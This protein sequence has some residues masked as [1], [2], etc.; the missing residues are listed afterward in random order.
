MKKTGI[1]KIVLLNLSL[2]FVFMACGPVTEQEETTDVIVYGGTSGAVTAAIQAKKMG[3]SVIMISPDKHLGGLT[4]GGLGWTDT[5][6]KEVIGG[7]SREFYQ[8]VYE[9]YTEDGAWKWEAQSDF[10]NKGQGTPA[11]DGE[12][13]TMWI[14]EPHVAEEVYDE[15]IE[16]LGI[17]V[18]RDEWLDRESG[19][20]VENGK[21]TAI[22]TLSGKEFKGKMFVD[23]TYEGDLMAAAGVSYHVGREGTS[24]YGEDWNGVQTGVFH[25]KHHFK[26]VDQPI[27][28]YIIPGDPSSGLLPKISGEDPGVKGEGDNKVQAYCFRTCMSINPDNQVPFPRPDNYDSTQYE[29]LGRIFDAGWTQWFGK[30]DMI[31]NKKTDTNN[32]GPFSSDNIGMNYDYPEA[33]YERRREIIKEHEDYQ[34]GLLYYVANDPRV[35]KETQD[36]FKK[37]GLAKDEFTDN[38]NWPHQ[39][40]VR[41]ARRMVGKYVMTENE[42][43][44]KRPTPESVGMGSY[45]IDSHN[46]QRYVDENGHVQ[47]EGDVGVPLPQPYEISYGSLVP[48]AD[49]IQNLVVPVA[50]SASHIAFGSIRME[51][52]FMILGQSAATAAVMAMDEGISV[53]ELPYSSLRTKLLEDGQVLTLADKIN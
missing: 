14:F 17:E 11:I 1:L 27:D 49:E 50:V 44:Q 23:A 31:P 20:T 36:E 5:G 41:E 10:G 6:K 42:L 34:K 8:R 4:A 33:S 19:V 13:R 51:P 32:H 35:P 52:V 7:L 37:W 29:L 43:L 3:K 40:Y 39:I 26:A 18:L 16:E 9:K 45:T 22:R 21:I 25:H 24:V 30:F 46:I 38:G 2:L 47:N 53:Q 12:F 15:W 48:K 28:P